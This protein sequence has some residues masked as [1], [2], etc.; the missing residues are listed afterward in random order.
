MLPQTRCRCL[1]AWQHTVRSSG[2][3][4]TWG[5]KWRSAELQWT[6]ID[7]TFIK[8]FGR[9]SL[10]AGGAVCGAVCCHAV[11]TIGRGVA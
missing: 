9:M 8:A 5:H 2:Q 3:F 7:T 10:C 6:W 1:A 4:P 11:S